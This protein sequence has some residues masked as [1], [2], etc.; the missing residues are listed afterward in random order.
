MFCFILLFFF[1]FKEEGATVE[2]MWGEGPS[3][4]RWKRNKEDR[5]RRRELKDHDE[6][7]LLRIYSRFTAGCKYCEIKGTPQAYG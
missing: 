7:E 2:W 4:G 6:V 1:F 5:S 3:H